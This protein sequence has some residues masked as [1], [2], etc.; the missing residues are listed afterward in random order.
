M[1]FPRIRKALGLKVRTSLSTPPTGD[2]QSRGVFDKF[3]PDGQ[4]G[5]SAVKAC[6]DLIASNLLLADKVVAR[7]TPEGVE[8][9]L[10]DHD[11]SLLMKNPSKMMNRFQFEMLMV[12]NLL[13][14]GNAYAK[15]RRV[16][17]TAVELIPANLVN[18]ELR[19]GRV[20]YNLEVL[21]K[22]G[23][24]F[25]GF[26]NEKADQRNVLH[27]SGLNPHHLWA[28]SYSP[29]HYAFRT[30]TIY[31]MSLERIKTLMEQGGISRFME[32]E[33][34]VDQD[35]LFAFVKRFTEEYKGKESKVDFA[36]IFPGGK[37]VQVPFANVDPGILDLL[38]FEVAEIARIFGAPQSLIG[39]HEK[40][41]SMRNAN[42]VTADF[43]SLKKK[44]LLPYSESFISEIERKLLYP[45]LISEKEK[46]GVRRDLHFIYDFTKT[47]EASE[48][49]KVM[50]LKN[51]AQSGVYTINEIRR[52]QGL[53]P[54]EGG[55]VL[56]GVTGAPS[57][58]ENSTDL[59][60]KE[61]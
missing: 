41:S 19:E 31:G 16:N 28:V 14:N 46:T 48:M 10:Y 11:V 33:E 2:P 30:A 35:Q 54:I 22:K 17:N 13:F 4:V 57:Q 45:A 1:K 61:E 24:I 34:G 43:T 32:T 59:T 44:A 15:I 3:Y 36:P 55:D 29:M 21:S 47:E 49:E 40:G 25:G 12:N 42:I 5:I 60:Q 37:M 52:M 26:V 56:P 7:K 23:P 53:P 27:I 50:I 18:T 20:L 51:R 39:H 8:E 6:V 9:R 58:N 38:R